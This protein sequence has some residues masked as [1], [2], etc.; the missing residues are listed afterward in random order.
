MKKKLGK[1]TAVIILAGSIFCLSFLFY[2]I[3]NFYL[4]IQP[5][6][7][8]SNTMPVVQTVPPPEAQERVIIGL[9][10]RLKIPR[11]D[12]DA[13]IESVGLA[14]GGVMDVPRGRDD[15]GWFNLGPRP[16][17]N[18]SAVIAGHF[19]WWRDGGATVFNELYK[20]REGDVLSV[21]ESTG[22]TIHFM[23]REVRTYDP[24][25]DATQIFTS[26]NGTHLNLVTCAGAWNDSQ[27]SYNERLAVFTD[28]IN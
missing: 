6:P 20:L 12:V 5:H 24:K 27:K 13:A 18:G 25:S 11:I 22:K 14:P 16:G 1:R 3:C 7:A 26:T 15:V 10:V 2:V 23:V 21:E 28:R 8:A 9:P 4:S 19:G 17:E